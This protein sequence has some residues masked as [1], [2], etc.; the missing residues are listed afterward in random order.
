MTLETFS[1][2]LGDWQS[3]I[4]KRASIIGDCTHLLVRFVF[5]LCHWWRENSAG[6]QITVC[7]RTSSRI[8][9]NPLQIHRVCAC[10]ETLR[11]TYSSKHTHQMYVG[12]SREVSV[13]AEQKLKCRHIHDGWMS[14]KSNNIAF[15]GSLSLP[16]S[17]IHYF[18]MCF[19][20]FVV[21][22]FVNSSMTFIQFDWNEM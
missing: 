19:S 5:K 3:E 16:R 14:N 4:K 6:M 20:F 7:Q 15:G 1:L 10:V 8:I 17:P 13:A 22:Q 2:E 18:S 11:Y 21:S 12:V 9:I